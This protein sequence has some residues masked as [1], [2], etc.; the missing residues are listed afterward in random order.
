MAK[1][2]RKQPPVIN[3]STEEVRPV[4]ENFPQTENKMSPTIFKLQVRKADSMEEVDRLLAN[5]PTQTDEADL[6]ILHEKKKFFAAKAY[7]FHC[8][9]QVK[10]ARIK[11]N[12]MEQG[13]ITKAE[14][15][16]IL[17]EIVEDLPENAKVSQDL[18]AEYD[19]A[20]AKRDA[21]QANRK[22]QKFQTTIGEALD[23]PDAQHA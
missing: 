14:C 13:S 18:L 23:S 16:R 15:L 7:R 21:F 19:V 12:A 17:T 9:E 4:T 6:K 22:R 10:K 2:T 5:M 3:A 11:I 20:A 8:V 1:R